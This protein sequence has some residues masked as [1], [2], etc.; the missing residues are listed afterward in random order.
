MPTIG[1]CPLVGTEFVLAPDQPRASCFGALTE[2]VTAVLEQK[3]DL[4]LVTYGEEHGDASA[5]CIIRWSRRRC[6]WIRVEGE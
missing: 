6:E 1:P 4:Y 2:T 3:D 5:P